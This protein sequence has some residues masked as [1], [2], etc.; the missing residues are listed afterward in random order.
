[1]HVPI[2]PSARA[3]AWATSGSASLSSAESGSTA[4]VSRRTPRLPMTPTSG[5]PLSLPRR[6]AQGLV[7]GRIG[8]RLQGVAGH[9][10]ELLV[11]KQR[12][13]R[14]DGILGADQ[15]QLAAGV[16]LLFLRGVRLQD[17]DQLGFLLLGRRVASCRRTTADDADQCEPSAARR[18]SAMDR[19]DHGEISWFG[20]AGASDRSTARAGR[21]CGSGWPRDRRRTP[22]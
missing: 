2:R 5:R 6:V 13:Q 17:G 12:G 18:P 4:L 15:R 3:A 8:V 10:R 21:G 14:G 9:V 11:A 7:D 20:Y 16:G 19:S 22:P 1:M